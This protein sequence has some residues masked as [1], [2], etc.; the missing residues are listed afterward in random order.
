MTRQGLVILCVFEFV[1]GF[2][3]CVCVCV[4]AVSICYVYVREV[5][6][7]LLYCV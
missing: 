3:V 5:R 4:Y 7:G 2:R 1:Q 6:L